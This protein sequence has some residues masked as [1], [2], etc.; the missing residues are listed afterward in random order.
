MDLN[1]FKV[2]E[3]TVE[4]SKNNS[5]GLLFLLISTAFI[6]GAY[7]GYAKEKFASGQW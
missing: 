1:N 2:K 5:G 6:Q 4:E 7:Y 3:I